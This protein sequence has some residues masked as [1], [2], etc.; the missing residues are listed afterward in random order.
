MA[1]RFLKLYLHICCVHWNFQLGGN[2]LAQDFR[3]AASLVIAMLFLTWVVGFFPPN[4][5]F[6]TTGKVEVFKIYRGHFG[7]IQICIDIDRQS[8]LIF[9]G[10]S[11]ALARCAI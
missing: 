9:C 3:F 7:L 10:G 8:C 6:K 4:V 5:P 2:I 11:C 1:G